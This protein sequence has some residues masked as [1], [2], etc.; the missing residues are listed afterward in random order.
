MPRSQPGGA[1]KGKRISKVEEAGM[2][3]YGGV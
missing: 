2:C 1:V 3:T